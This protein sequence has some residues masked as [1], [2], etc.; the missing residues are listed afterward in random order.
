[1]EMLIP[2][3]FISLT[4]LG[5][6]FYKILPSSLNKII[7]FILSFILSILTIFVFLF[8]LFGKTY[9]GFSAMARYNS[10]KANFENMKSFMIS[11]IDKCNGNVTVNTFLDSKGAIRTIGACPLN[12]SPSGQVDALNYFR[13]FINDKFKNPYQPSL[14]I[15]K[16]GVIPIKIPGVKEEEGYISLTPAE[17]SRTLFTLRANLGQLPNSM[18]YEVLQQNISILENISILDK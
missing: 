16:N 13:A 5:N 12:N 17:D 6:I 18:T 14:K 1:M 8:F 15:V 4:I 7:K 3:F 10:S 2:L 11:E 9:Q